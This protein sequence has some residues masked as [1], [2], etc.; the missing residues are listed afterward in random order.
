ME[1]IMVAGCVL[2]TVIW[3]AFILLII[4][5]IRKPKPFVDAKTGMTW[6]EMVAS[7]E[8]S[9]DLYKS[10]IEDQRYKLGRLEELLYSTDTN[11]PAKSFKRVVR[12]DTGR[13][14]AWRKAIRNL[15]NKK[16]DI[17]DFKRY[18]LDKQQHA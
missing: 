1:W 8:Q 17:R 5:K 16:K 18:I 6:D 10:R 3:I 11:V 2:L 9:I 14:E 12:H 15:P 13:E 4:N 7:Y